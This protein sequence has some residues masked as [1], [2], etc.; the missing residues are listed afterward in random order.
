M[1]IIIV[2]FKK[3]LPINY[4]LYK[5]NRITIIKMWFFILSAAFASYLPGTK[6]KNYKIN[7]S[8]SMYAS[9]IDSSVTQLPFDYYYLNF[10]KAKTEP[11][12]MAPTIDHAGNIIELSPYEILMQV[13]TYCKSLCNKSNSKNDIKALNWMIENKYSVNWFLDSLPSGYRVSLEE[14]R[15]NLEFFQYGVPLGF[16]N[17]GKN[18]IYNHQHIILK[19]YHNEKQESWTIVGF[20]IQPLS[21]NTT[22][23]S[24]C[25]KYNWE[26]IIKSQI[27]Y[28]QKVVTAESDYIVKENVNFLIYPQEI[29]KDIEY[30]YSVSFENSNKKWASRWDVYLYAQKTEIHWLSIVNSFG[31]VLLLSILV[32]HLFRK[33]LNS[34]IA[35]YNDRID[36]DPEADSGW[37]QLAGDIFRSPVHP[38]LY[39]TIIGSGIQ[40]NLMAFL[41]L[42][43][44]C[45]GFLS[46]D[47]RGDLLTMMLFL[48]AFMGCFGGYASARLYKLFG[49]LQWK[50][51]SLITS[52]MLPGFCF[53]VFFIV[54]F[55]IWE[56]DSSGAVD[57]TSLIELLFVWFGISVPLVFLG[58]AIGYRKEVLFIPCKIS[59]IPKPLPNQSSKWINFVCLL[60]GSLPFGCM[61]IE[62]NYVMK[63]I[64]NYT[65][66]Y[67]LFGF[68]FLCFIVLIIT[69]AEVSIL[70]T[71]IVMCKEDYRWWWISLSV[72]G[73][74]GIYFFMYSAIY[75]FLQ[76]HINR[77]S[78][79]VLYFGYMLIG[80]IIYALITGSVGFLSTFIFLKKIFSMVKSD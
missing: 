55:L 47:H 35:S 38:N 70:M 19:V 78:S 49:G 46:P 27:N 54:N 57:F 1:V 17:K 11:Q 59:K 75:Y 62:L 33:I 6:P 79:T 28:K 20:V 76:L 66:F 26:E 60:S 21:F 31:M 56:E 16:T 44:S 10:C 32:A 25:D 50:A 29:R 58:S 39:S 69:S 43:F 61:F 41:T 9:N 72:A 71:Y 3:K 5:N 51:N 15:T 42:V 68:L 40:L 12:S 74:S 48:F 22:S 4:I 30:T 34:E 53:I 24:I 7:E 67:Y 52:F 2:Y 18:Y 8:I 37:K 14:T 63:S 13:T 64:W 77:F 73:S 36:S 45:I 65:T 80:S 23:E